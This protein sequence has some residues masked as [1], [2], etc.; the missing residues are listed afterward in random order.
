MNLIGSARHF[1]GNTADGGVFRHFVIVEFSNPDS[2]HP[3]VLESPDVL[4][5]KNV[6]FG[7]QLFAAGPKDRATEDPSCCHFDVNR[8]RLHRSLVYK[9]CSVRTRLF[10]VQDYTG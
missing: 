3:L 9:P 4:Q 6:A 10:V 8:L 5:A 1:P 7:K 2:L